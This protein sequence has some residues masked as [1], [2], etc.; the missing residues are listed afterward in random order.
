MGRTSGYRPGDHLAECDRCGFTYR[1][2]RLFTEW[3]GLRV[4]RQCYDKEPVYPEPGNDKISVK[5]PRP[6][7][8]TTANATTYSYL[9]IGENLFPDPWISGDDH[10][11][12]VGKGELSQDHVRYNQFSRKLSAVSAELTISGCTA[13][14]T[15]RIKISA[16]HDTRRTLVEIDGNESDIFDRTPLSSW[17]DGV[18]YHTA[19]SSIITIALR[20]N[21]KYTGTNFIS[22]IDGIYVQEYVNEDI[23]IPISDILSNKKPPDDVN[24]D[25]TI[26]PD[27]VYI[28][29]SE[30]I[31]KDPYIDDDPTRYVS[32]SN[33]SA[34]ISLVRSTDQYKYSTHSLNVYVDGP[35]GIGEYANG[36]A[37]V[38]TTLLPSTEYYFKI[39]SYDGIAATS[40]YFGFGDSTMTDLLVGLGTSTGEWLESNTLTFTTPAEITDNNIYFGF[41][42][43]TSYFPPYSVYFDGLSLTRYINET[44]P[45]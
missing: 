15:Y 38:A 22:Y 41:K 35:L 1:N 29:M 25:N 43:T 31:I 24:I 11:V 2:S 33:N 3:T 36:G 40:K 30:N 18:T 44:T 5:D 42:N 32:F 12:W 14:K 16:W 21:K 34:T 39:W 13:G 7:Q 37:S 4:C 9:Y 45:F 10:A 6:R 20:T 26:T 27:P 19:T 8:E 28:G 17:V 23:K